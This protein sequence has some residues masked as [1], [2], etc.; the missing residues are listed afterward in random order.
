MA[1]GLSAFHYTLDSGANYY[2]V[3]AIQGDVVE[4]DPGAEV[5]PTITG[6]FAL[7]R[8]MVTAVANLQGYLTGDSLR[9]LYGAGFRAITNSLPDFE[10]NYGYIGGSVELLT[11]CKL[12]TWTMSGSGIGTDSMLQFSCSIPAAGRST[13]IAQSAIACG[14]VLGFADMTVKIDGIDYSVVGYE[15]GLNN[16]LVPVQYANKAG[17]TVAN[18]RYW[19]NHLREAA[20]VWT[21]RLKLDQYVAEDPWSTVS[22]HDITFDYSFADGKLLKTFAGQIAFADTVINTLPKPLT[23]D[24][25][26]WDYEF[27]VAPYAASMTFTET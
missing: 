17:V 21:C 5:I 7:N 18:G 1:T 4:I 11:A 8:S 19:A 12:N 9:L 20:P 22:A 23:A 24:S 15:I 26:F 25:F 27:I 3:G 16:N 13:G 2:P 14:D 6:D 10:C